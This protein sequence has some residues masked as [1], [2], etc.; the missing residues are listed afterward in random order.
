MSFI[1]TKHLGGIHMRKI[2]YNSHQI[3]V[4]NKVLWDNRLYAETMAVATAICDF[5]HRGCTVAEVAELLNCSEKMVNKHIDYLLEAGH[6][7][8]SLPSFRSIQE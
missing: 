3:I 8:V 4:P 5:D 1:Q 7:D 2:Y 6:G